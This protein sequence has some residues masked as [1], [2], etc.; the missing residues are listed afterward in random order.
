MGGIEEAGCERMIW[1][2]EPRD[3]KDEDKGATSQTEP[4]STI[5]REDKERVAR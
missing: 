5:A 4:E 3:D 1:M 2:K